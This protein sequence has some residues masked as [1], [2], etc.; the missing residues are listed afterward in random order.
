MNL[1]GK[2]KTCFLNGTKKTCFLNGTPCIY[3]GLRTEKPPWGGS[4][5]KNTHFLDKKKPP[6]VILM[7]FHCWFRKNIVELSVKTFYFAASSN[8]VGF[9][10]FAC[11]WGGGLMKVLD[12]TRSQWDLFEF[13]IHVFQSIGF[14]GISMRS[15]WICYSRIPKYC[16][17]WDLNEISSNPIFLRYFES[18]K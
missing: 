12:S 18:K 5:K 14:E 8:N 7:Q 1:R 11:L 17:R 6:F 9:Y 13:I 3:T 16:I 4:A 15:L 10:L 2:R